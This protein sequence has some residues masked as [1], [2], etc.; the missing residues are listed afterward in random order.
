MNAT[1]SIVSVAKKAQDLYRQ[2][3]KIERDV[4]TRHLSLYCL[5]FSS[6]MAIT[7]DSHA[8]EPCHPAEPVTLCPP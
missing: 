6:G 7:S 3:Q 2:Q 1:K 4:Q 5:P 8:A